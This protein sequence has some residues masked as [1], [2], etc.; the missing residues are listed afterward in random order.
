MK[1]FDV[2]QHPHLAPE[3]VKNGFSWPGFFFNWIWA[4][5]KGLPGKGL[6]ILG[7]MIV[8]II[9]DAAAEAEGIVYALFGLG[10]CIWVGVSGNE[11]R[12]ASLVQR[13]FAKSGTVVAVSPDG[14]I[15]Q[16]LRDSPGPVARPSHESAAIPASGGRRPCP[17][18]AEMILPAARFCRYCS[19]DVDPLPA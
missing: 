15:A 8:I 10:I 19:R 5:V 16:I 6:L 1:T 13:G 4:F 12:V 3:A 7:G 17:Y 18:C 2:F 14:A 9:F 11:W